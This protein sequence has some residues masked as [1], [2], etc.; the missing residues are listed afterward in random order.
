MVRMAGKKEVKNRE[1][2]R[3]GCGEAKTEQSFSQV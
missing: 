2:I 3:E 1:R